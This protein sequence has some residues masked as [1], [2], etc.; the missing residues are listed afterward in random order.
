MGRY[1]IPG[2]QKVGYLVTFLFCAAT[3]RVIDPRLLPFLIRCEQDAGLSSLRIHA[4]GN[5]SLSIDLIFSPAS[6]HH[7]V[8]RIRT[9]RVPCRIRLVRRF[10]RLG[11]L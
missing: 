4:P 6:K 7:S 2:E 1:A 5:I 10:S 3:P 8:R 11:Y 9:D